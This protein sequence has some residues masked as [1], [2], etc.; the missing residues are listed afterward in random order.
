MTLSSMVMAKDPYE[1]SNP[2]FSGQGFS[3]HILTLEQMRQRNKQTAKDEEESLAR[4]LQRELDNSN[5]NRF[6]NNFESRVYAQLSKQLVESLFGEDPQESGTFDLAGN[7]VEYYS[8][9]TTVTLTITAAD[10]TVTTITI[11]VGG[12]GI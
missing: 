3:S 9:G 2:S 8:D 4:E 6:L 5:I 11:P 1:F 7:L 10:G 12:L